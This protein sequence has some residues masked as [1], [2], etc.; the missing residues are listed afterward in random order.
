MDGSSNGNVVSIFGEASCQN[1]EEDE[2]RREDNDDEEEE[3]DKDEVDKLARL[4]Q[5]FLDIN[6]PECAATVMAE[7][8]EQMMLEAA[9]HI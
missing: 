1:K 8:R 3:G 5:N 4:T 9:E 2:W 6:R 7:E